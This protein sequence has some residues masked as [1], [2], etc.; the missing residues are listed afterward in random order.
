M[1]LKD[2]Q[3]MINQTVFCASGRK[4]ESGKVVFEV[5]LEKGNGNL[6]ITATDDKRLGFSNREVGNDFPDFDGVFVS[7][8]VLQKIAKRKRNTEPLSISVSGN[9][10]NFSIGSSCVSTKTISCE[11]INL[12][13][14]ERVSKLYPFVAPVKVVGEFIRFYRSIN[15]FKH[16]LPLS[17]TVERKSLLEALGLVSVM[18]EPWC[19][20]LCIVLSPG[21]LALHTGN[22]DY[23]AETEITCEYGGEEI[24]LKFH[25]NSF[26]EIVEHIDAEYIQIQFNPRKSTAAVLPV[27]ERGYYYFISQVIGGK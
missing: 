8:M 19:S 6:V 27:P 25:A 26:I 18:V 23:S 3:E 1:Q 4:V 22:N 7:A 24:K 2:F 9:V 5:Y 13:N 14:E 20:E 11:F 16:I 17:F 10:V 12:Y 15:G 21:N